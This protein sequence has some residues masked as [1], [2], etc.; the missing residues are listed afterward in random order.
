M[1]KR[2]DVPHPSDEVAVGDLVHRLVEDGKAF[3]KA[4]AD[5][6]KAIAGEKASALKLPAILFGAAFLFVQ[7]AITVLAVAV[8]LWLEPMIGPLL[9]GLVAFLLFA[10]AAGVMA[11]VALSKIKE[12]A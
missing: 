3:A 8:C 1:L 10:G 6:A 7:S 5:L 4:E 9:A 12:A 11:W 2:V